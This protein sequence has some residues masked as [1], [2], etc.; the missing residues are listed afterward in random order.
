MNEADTKIEI[1]N[2]KSQEVGSSRV[3]K[4]RKGVTT[5]EE[6][7]KVLATMKDDKHNLMTVIKSQHEDRMKKEDKKLELFENMISA[8]THTNKS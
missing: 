6:V 1:G 8:F 4:Q 2:D 3:P 5:N 7:M